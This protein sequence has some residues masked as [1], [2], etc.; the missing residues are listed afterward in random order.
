MNGCGPEWQPLQ[1]HTMMLVSDLIIF[2]ACVQ[3]PGAAIVALG[4]V[5]RWFVCVCVCACV[6]ECVWTDC[7]LNR[8]E[9]EWRSTAVC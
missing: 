9:D 5:R 6:R 4:A 1:F 8:D 7:R 2:H 3:V